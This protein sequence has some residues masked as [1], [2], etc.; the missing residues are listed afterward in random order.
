MIHKNGVSCVPAAAIYPN[1]NLIMVHEVLPYMRAPKYVYT[2]LI[3]H[4]CLHIVMPPENGNCHGPEF[5]MREMFAPNRKRSIEWL[6][7]KNFPVM[8]G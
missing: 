3:F 7:R 5:C 2:Y 6:Q 8:D 1:Q 4:E